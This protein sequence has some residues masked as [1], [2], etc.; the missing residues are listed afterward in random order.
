MA[1]LTDEDYL[2]QIDQADLLALTRADS[3]QRDDPDDPAPPAPAPATGPTVRDRA[4]AN[5][6][7][8]VASY[9]R[10]RFDMVA[11]YALAGP[12]RNQQLVMICVD[13]ALWHLVPR[14]A[15]KNVSQV[16][17]LRYDAAIKWLTMAQKGQS[18]PDL[19]LYPADTA[20]PQRHSIFS[21]G[22]NP[23]RSQDF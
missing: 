23:R 4:E 10:G 21:W 14:V 22:S 18:N 13:V 20:D 19:P 9:L 6:L 16:R 12:A 1:F 7:A 8:E 17:E 2:A 3:P 11:A 15:F 5:A